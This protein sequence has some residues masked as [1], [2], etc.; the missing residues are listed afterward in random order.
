MEAAK[1]IVNDKGNRAVREYLAHALAN[2]K[3]Y[4]VHISFE[5]CNLSRA[6]VTMLAEALED[7]TTIGGFACVGNPFNFR[8]GAYNPDSEIVVERALTRTKAP[9]T[10]W[11]WNPLP[12]SLIEDR[13]IYR[14][15]EQ[16]TQDQ[17]QYVAPPTPQQRQ[18]T[19]PAAAA[20][21]AQRAPEQFALEDRQLATARAKLSVEQRDF[22]TKTK[23][24]HELQML[25]TE[26]EIELKSMRDK[27][28]ALDAHILVAKQGMDDALAVITR[29][30][31]AKAASSVSKRLRSNEEDDN[32]NLCGIC[33]D[34]PKDRAFYRC[35]HQVCAECADR[36]MQETR[37]CPFCKASIHDILRLF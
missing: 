33:L 3:I 28:M 19:A 34:N 23:E 35:G 36:V 10:R 12:Y 11:N 22:T 13:R 8:Y 26:R 20:A 37:S 15:T 14:A 31:S 17:Q 2:C 25:I 7:N 4:N 9:I 32:A 24:K 21:P 18:S 1:R 27:V 5:F 16:F 29:L 6:C 30:D